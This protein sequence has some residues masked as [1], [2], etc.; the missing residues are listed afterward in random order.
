MM[1]T[2]FNILG[3]C[4]L[5]DIFSH[6]PNDGGHKINQYV[7]SF[8]P[9]FSFE[10]GT[11]VDIEK[12]NKIDTSDIV[13]NF[14]KRCI[15][16]NI[17][18]SVFD[19]I[20]QK[21]SNYL[22]MDMGLTRINYYI[23]ENGQHCFG[24]YRPLYD[25]MANE[26]LIPNIVQT[27][28]FN[29]LEKDKIRTRIAKYCQRIKSIYNINKIILFEIK[30]STLLYDNQ[31]NTITSFPPA[32][33]N[34]AYQ[35]NKFI[36]FCFSVAKEELKGCHVVYMPKNVV[37]DAYHPLKK[38]VLHFTQEYYDYGLE[39]INII[40]QN[41]PKEE[42]EAALKR[43]CQDTETLY[44]KKYFGILEKS[45]LTSSKSNT[46]LKRKNIF[47]SK[48]YSIFNSIYKDNI[49]IEIFFTTNKIKKIVV[50]GY[51]DLY[52]YIK[53]HFKKNIKVIGF[54]NNKDNTMH[55]EKILDL[56]SIPRDIP[57]LI[58][59][60]T[61]EDLIYEKLK[62]LNFKAFKLTEIIDWT[63]KNKLQ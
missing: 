6:H 54:F 59:D 32:T 39:A 15:L 24:G 42:E 57:I 13:S 23:L 37:C 44:A 61:D 31:K 40:T 21:E 19:Y 9:L 47:L 46:T 36:D 49:D 53:V 33:I 20:E 38:G 12:Y 22:L 29:F 17:N 51:N 35:Q 55:N 62:K 48:M 3:I 50:Y 5:R 14:I 7:N 45:L 26:G 10:A 43:L 52:E 30:N 41:M 11:P 16:F 60:V 27:K 2:S 25:R 1:T 18:G 28:A 58:I 8:A 63:Y 34:K 56:L 4:V